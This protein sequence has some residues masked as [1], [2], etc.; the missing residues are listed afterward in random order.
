MEGAT[1][2]NASKICLGRGLFV[3]MDKG[4]KR[5]SD[6]KLCLGFEMVSKNRVKIDELKVG[7]EEGPVCER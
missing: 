3:R 2:E 5:L 4:E 7:G 1:F 6:E